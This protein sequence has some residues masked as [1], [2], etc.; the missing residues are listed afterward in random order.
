MAEKFNADDFN[1][2]STLSEEMIKNEFDQAA[3]EISEYPIESNQHQQHV[4]KRY[5]TIK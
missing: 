2:K 1:L 3:F 4:I 5:M